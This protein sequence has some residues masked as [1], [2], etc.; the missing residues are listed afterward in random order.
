MFDMKEYQKI[1]RKNHKDKMKKFN[2]DYYEKNK[3]MFYEH[4]K[5]Y[6]QDHKEEITK[7]NKN[8]QNT[9]KGIFIQSRC[10]CKRRNVDFIVTEIDFIKWYNSQ[11]QVCYYCGRTLEEIKQDTEETE[12]N[13]KCRLTIERTDNNKG[14]QL[15]NIVLACNRCNIIKSNYFTKKEM[16]EI[17]KIIRSKR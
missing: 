5:K 14:Y 4:N 9:P 10:R 8:Y 1:Y 6:Y 11:K 16:I 3:K 17:G 7:S 13:K 15:D 12:R 2:K